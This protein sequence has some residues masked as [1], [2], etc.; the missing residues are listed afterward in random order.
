M[1]YQETSGAYFFGGNGWTINSSS[2]SY[3]EKLAKEL[4]A[5]SYDLF[6]ELELACKEF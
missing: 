3:N 6:R 4:W 2:L 1:I 5:T